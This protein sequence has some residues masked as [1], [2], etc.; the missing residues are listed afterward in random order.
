MIGIKKSEYIIMNDEVGQEFKKKFLKEYD[1][2]SVQEDE[3]LIIIT[4]GETFDTNRFMWI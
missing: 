3:K 4:V 2:V 1:V